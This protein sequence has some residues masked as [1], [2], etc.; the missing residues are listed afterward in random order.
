MQSKS[1]SDSNRNFVLTEEK[2]QQKKHCMP[3]LAINVYLAVLNRYS[4]TCECMWIDN[5][6]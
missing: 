6:E 2:V 5:D 1:R 3:E 4:S